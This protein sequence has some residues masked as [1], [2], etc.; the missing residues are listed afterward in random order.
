MTP[1]APTTSGA[2]FTVTTEQIVEAMTLKQLQA[3]LKAVDLGSNEYTTQNQAPTALIHH[4]VKQ[5]SHPDSSVP[6]RS[7][8][9]SPATFLPASSARH[10]TTSPRS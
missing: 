2:S 1:V 6:T 3:L 10:H 8:E 4:A 9:G 7:P 5:A